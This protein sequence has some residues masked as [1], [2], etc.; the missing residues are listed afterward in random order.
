M[1]EYRNRAVHAAAEDEEIEGMMFQLKR[2]VEALLE[3]HVGARY[4]FASLEEA[5]EFMDLPHDLNTL[6]RRAKR[7]EFAQAFLAK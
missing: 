6:S 2:H 3:F 1:K 4:R 5:G 7:L